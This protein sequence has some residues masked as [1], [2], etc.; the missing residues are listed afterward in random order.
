MNIIAVISL[1]CCLLIAKQIIRISDNNFLNQFY[2]FFYSLELL[3]S[4]IL[5]ISDKDY[6]LSNGLNLSNIIESFAIACVIA[7]VAIYCGQKFANKVFGNYRQLNIVDKIN[8]LSKRYRINSVSTFFLVCFC[9]TIVS[10]LDVA[11]YIAVFALSFS[12]STA[13]IGLTWTKLSKIN[14]LLWIIALSVNFVFHA[15]QGSRGTAFF[16]IIFIIIGY[17]ISI[18]FNKKLLKRQTII[19]LAIAIFSMPLLSFIASFRETQGRGL[20]VN[21]ENLELLWKVGQMYETK[22]SDDNIQTSLGRMLIEANPAVIYMTPDEVGYRYDDYIFD[23]II[24]IFSLAGDEGR[25]ID[26]ETR[27]SVGFGTGVA[28]RYGFS[29][30]ATTSVEWPVFADGFSRFG[31]IGLFFY[32]FMFAVLL[33]GFEKAVSRL[34]NKNALVSMTLMLFILYNGALSYMYSYYAFLKLIVFRMTLVWIVTYYVSFVTK[35]SNS[36]QLI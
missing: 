13:F 9:F 35:R 17:L 4:I 15:V 34:W 6:R 24:S 1:V 7:C 23:E 3:I 26:R 19:Y 8:F 10:S 31:Y 2:S 12:F 33:A 18:R 16:P 36:T 20:E 11:Y 28:T 32:S 25:E 21:M 22:E 29:V 5:V 27:G 30:N 14:K